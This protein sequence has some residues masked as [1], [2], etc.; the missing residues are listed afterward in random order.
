MEA[1]ARFRT[2]IC[3]IPGA[4]YR[5]ALDADWTVEFISDAVEEITGYPASDFVGNRRRT[6]AS[7]I[8][9]EDL[10]AAKR[11]VREALECGTPFSLAY[12]ILRADGVE[13]WIGEKGRAIQDEN[14]S[15][16]SLDGTIAPL[17]RFIR[18]RLKTTTSCSSEPR[19]RPP[20]K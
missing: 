13:S 6:Y 8:H 7:I 15:V 3:D 14:G 4:L 2:L 9:P 17:A 10:P 5:R 18:S 20:S 16:L 12:R 1:E 19:R 11:G